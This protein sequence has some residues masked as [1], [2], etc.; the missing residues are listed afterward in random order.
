[1]VLI[2]VNLIGKQELVD[3]D[4]KEITS[5]K[6]QKRNKQNDLGPVK[7]YIKSQL[8]SCYPSCTYTRN[9]VESNLNDFYLTTQGGCS[10]TD[11]S[12]HDIINNLK[13]YDVININAIVCGGIDFQHREGSKV[14]EFSF[15]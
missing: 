11:K 13:E 4:F 1:M 7:A 10:I 12:C 15:M 6:S 2:L 3:L 8:L 9:F 14:G 5:N